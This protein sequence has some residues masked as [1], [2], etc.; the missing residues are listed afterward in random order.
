MRSTILQSQITPAAEYVVNK[1]MVDNGIRRKPGEALPMDSRLRGMPQRLRQLCEQRILVPGRPVM[2]KAE[3][4]ENL[5][6]ADPLAETKPKEDL[7]ELSLGKLKERCLDYGLSISGNT[8]TL[9]RRLRAHL[10]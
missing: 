4:A 10:G 8:A 5:V 2:E 7:D 1:M 3:G 6:P 9:R